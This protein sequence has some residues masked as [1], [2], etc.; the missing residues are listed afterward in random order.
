MKTCAA[1]VVL[2]FAA[3]AWAQVRTDGSVGAARSLTGPNY[4]I[5]ESL[6]R[7]AGSNLFHSFQVFSIGR[8]EAAVFSTT[9]PTLSN[10]IGR[11]TGGEPSHIQGAIR[12]QAAGGAPALWLLNPAGV[13][14]GAGA[15]IDVPGAFHVSTADAL[16]FPDGE[17]HVDLAR[18]ST[19]SSAPPEAFGF[20][21]TRRASVTVAADL[22][23]GDRPFSIVAG[24]VVL[25]DGARVENGAGH[26]TVVAVGAQ[27]QQ[28]PVDASPAARLGG[29]VR[30]GPGSYLATYGAGPAVGDVRVEAGRIEADGASDGFTGIASQS[31]GDGPAGKV[32]VRADDALVL[33]RGALVA[34]YA[35]GG[36]AAAPV[37]VRAQSLFA[38]AQGVSFDT[39]ILSL[40]TAAGRGADLDVRV[41]G[42]LDLRA[43]GVVVAAAQ[44][45]G[46]AGNVE[47]HAGSIR[48]TGSERY[49]G[50]VLRIAGPSETTPGEIR[51]V[52]DGALEFLPGGL[53]A[54]RTEG[55]GR[56]ATIDVRA[57]S[58]H[59]DGGEEFGTGIRATSSGAGASGDVQVR[60]DG[61]LVLRG[62]AAISSYGEH[63]DGGAVHVHAGSLDLDGLF[64]GVSSSG[65]RA[66]GGVAVEVAGDA[67]I[68]N[69]AELRSSSFGTEAAGPLALR[70]G[71]VT[72][73]GG[74]LLTQGDA[75][76]AI[77]VA[78]RGTLA[79]TAGGEV[80]A[81]TGGAVEVRA[82]TLRM[83]DGI[84]ATNFY[85]D[86]GVSRRLRVEADAVTLE[87]GS[88]IQSRNVGA[89]NGGTVEVTAGRLLADDSRIESYASQGRGGDVHVQVAGRMELQNGA[90]VQ[91]ANGANDNSS[92][93]DIFI[94]AQELLIANSH[95]D[96]VNFFSAGRAGDITVRVAGAMEITADGRTLSTGISSDHFGRGPRAGG[97]GRVT[98]EAGSL[99]VVSTT[100]SQTDV[101]IG[102][103]TSDGTAGALDINVRGDLRFANAYISST[104]SGPHEGGAIR[105]RAG[106]ALRIED[107]AITSDSFASG[108]A[109]A[110]ELQARSITLVGSTGFLLGAQATSSG[111]GAG[112]A[113]SVTVRATEALRMEGYSQLSSDT[114]GP[115]N[116]GTVSVEAGSLTMTSADGVASISSSTSA[117][118]HAGEVHLRVAGAMDMQGLSHVHTS[119]S[120]N[121]RAGVLT[122][123]AGSL[124]IAG[125]GKSDFVT[126]IASKGLAEEGSTGDA[127]SVR[128]A[129][130]G[131]LQ[132]LAGAEIGSNAWGGAAGSVMV[133]AGRILVSGR[134]DDG[135][136]ASRISAHAFDVSSGQAGN[137]TLRAR[138]AIVLADGAFITTRND[139]VAAGPPA[140]APGTLLLAAPHI[141]L[142][143]A[144]VSA[145]SQGN[146]AASDVVIDAGQLLLVQRGR[147]STSAV[148]T[149]GDGGRIRIT[150]PV[151]ALDTGF[152]Q[153]N[154]TAQ[155]AQGGDI[156]LAVGAL[157]S[158]HGSVRV[159]GDLPLAF[160]PAAR[161]VNV[162]QAAAPT[163]LSGTVQITAPQLDP[164][165]ALLVL[166]SSLLPEQPLGKSPCQGA[167][168]SSLALVGRGSLPPAPWGPA[169]A[170]AW[171]GA[172]APAASLVRIARA[173]C[174]QR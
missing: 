92:T 91:S 56:G 122:V 15:S 2:A 124:R 129:V 24:D 132:V 3:G 55:N 28:V 98:I 86:A 148:G 153:A 142:H 61:P 154:A 173:G 19:F 13:L 121:G 134:T 59:A 7:R 96:S 30:I 120:G 31:V 155:R 82:A 41:A 75:G 50:A 64:T 27:A 84:I 157:L 102:A 146:F 128:V 89:G 23:T 22:A 172:A 161:G 81:N 105:I 42:T 144:T 162:V 17:F 127:G 93:G 83:N 174:A 79:V 125:T 49:V 45:A 113:G 139:S 65:L 5:P 80:T 69:D 116:A 163:G 140:A 58:L 32:T 54:S 1:L 87:N 166:A 12:L 88:A 66:S 70:A 18:A 85:G 168:G 10:V 67:R 63:A 36:G 76:G 103:S 48:L 37:A 51:V 90:Y 95:V 62:A 111:M 112:G 72:I 8:G 25:Q 107:T 29:D 9:T 164:A 44:G 109:G 136:G 147:I 149:A 135:L 130:A 100:D 160:D 110:I 167:A 52:A 73:A 137:L 169:G 43:G 68:A 138:E 150:A 33:T 131:D 108:R 4:A 145:G 123:E 20:L 74:A 21:G 156:A 114:S 16:R 101:G 170:A 104:T 118:G 71:E 40:A 151:A 47:V 46:A 14:F 141:A 117:S 11:V 53:V 106:G 77:T 165:G 34:S 158:S 26:L 57:A 39:G 152:V 94:D 133:E 143:D 171:S 78:A 97:A 119:T 126:A 60:V 115:G 38:D 159:G 99:S 6:G 35:D